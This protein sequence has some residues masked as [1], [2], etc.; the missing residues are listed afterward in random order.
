MKISL[1]QFR[2]SLYFSDRKFDQLNILL[3]QF[4]P[5]YNRCA[6][7]ADPVVYKLYG[8]EV[9]KKLASSDL[10]VF[11]IIIP[12][13]ES[14]KTIE[15][16]CKC[17][18]Q[19]LSCGIDRNSLI[20]SLGGGATSDLTGFVASCYM[21]GVDVIHIPT[22]LLAMVDAAVGGKT[23]I[24]TKDTKNLIGTIHHP[25]LVYITDH[26]L[27]SL[28]D[29]EFYAGMAEIIKCAVVADASFFEELNNSTKQI[30]SRDPHILQDIIY[31]TCAIKADIVK[32][33]EKDKN[34]RA[35]LNYGHTFAHAIE[36]LTKYNTFLHGEAVS[37]GMSCA[38][39]TGVKL[40]TVDKYFVERQ[41]ELCKKF[42]LPI[43]FPEID[44]NM[45]IETMKRDK[46][47]VSKKINL[48][49][50]QKI[51]KV[52]RAEDVKQ[53]LILDAINDKKLEDAGERT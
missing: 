46:K 50:P 5:R 13:S 11:P 49:I 15:Q 33:D 44:A 14:C 21:R 51:G 2:S 52:I 41:D 35:Y 10:E 22:T 42:S 16:A 30:I 17:W 8:D 53:Q 27:N 32:R 4:Q 38:A 48:I 45:L 37:I 6:L 12:Q 20:V 28:P 26:V 25:R 3:N 24:N 31:K 47:S 29:R 7:I 18:E 1:E 36:T 43:A 40:N 34:I 19:L 9:T 39:H 23:G